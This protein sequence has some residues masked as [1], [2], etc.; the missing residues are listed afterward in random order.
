LGCP[1]IVFKRPFEE[2]VELELDEELES[3][4]EVT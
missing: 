3:G 2:I 1:F 4:G